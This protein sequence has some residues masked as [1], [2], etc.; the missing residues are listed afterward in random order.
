MGELSQPLPTCD[1]KWEG[2]CYPWRNPP[3]NGG[4]ILEV[5]LEYP[6][7]TKKTYKFPLAPERLKINKEELSNY[8]MKCL[9]VEGKKTVVKLPKLILNLKDKKNYVIYYHLSKFYEYLGLKVKKIHSI[10]SFNQSP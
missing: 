7:N 5:D 8:Q 4:C 9:K 1:F 10:I 3:D 2:T 6:L